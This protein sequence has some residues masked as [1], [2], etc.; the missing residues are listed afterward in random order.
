VNEK[1]SFKKKRIVHKIE[2]AEIEPS[3]VSRNILDKIKLKIKINKWI[4][5]HIKATE[6]WQ[7]SHNMLQPKRRCRKRSKTSS[8]ANVECYVQILP[9]FQ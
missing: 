9:M 6:K 5:G 7:S 2:A 8:W 1:L 4:L 3:S